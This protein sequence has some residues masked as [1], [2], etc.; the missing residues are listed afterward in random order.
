MNFCKRG[1][2]INDITEVCQAMFASLGIAR[3]HV[4]RKCMVRGIPRIVFGNLFLLSKWDQ[5]SL[6]LPTHHPLEKINKW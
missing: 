2:N 4:V 5:S 1:E 6:T 3:V